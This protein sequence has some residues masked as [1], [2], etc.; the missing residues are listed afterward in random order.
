MAR[1][2]D[3]RTAPTVPLPVGALEPPPDPGAR[4][5]AD[6]AAS[7]CERLTEPP[8]CQVVILPDTLEGPGRR[9][10]QRGDATRGPRPG[11]AAG[12]RPSAS[13]DWPQCDKSINRPPT[14]A[15]LT[16]FPVPSA[17]VT[18]SPLGSR[19]LLTHA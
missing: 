2:A 4:S 5:R 15:N 1:Y 14:A 9:I 13:R 3:P 6:P 7:P 17:H 19:P 18:S 11:R 12:C 8:D 10:G 16:S